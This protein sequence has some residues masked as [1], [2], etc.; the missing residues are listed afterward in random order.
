MRIKT[1]RPQV[2]VVVVNM[3]GR[4][5]LAPCLE[6]LDKVDYSADRMEVILVDNGSLDGSV[7]FVQH[8]HPD[9]KVIQNDH[10]EGFARA[11]NQGA[12]AADGEFVVFLNNDMRVHP[13][14]LSELAAAARSASDVAA[15]GGRILSWDGNA[16][17]FEGAAL[18]FYGMGFQP[19][20]DPPSE[21]QLSEIL[22]G[23]G[24]SLL[25]DR[26]V[27]MEIGGFDPDYFAYFE[28]VDL[29][30]RMWLLGHRVLYA[31][32]ALT[33]HRGHGTSSRMPTAQVAV[34]YE[35][36][37][38]YTIIK[39]YN[40]ANLQRVLPAALLLLVRRAAIFGRL[41]KR[42]FRMVGSVAS[43]PNP[44]GPTDE[45][46]PSPPRTSLRQAVQ[47]FAQF[48]RDSG[49]YAATVE[50]I[51][52]VLVT[53]HQKLGRLL[54]SEASL[55]P[56]QALAHLVAADDVIDALPSLMEKRADIQSRRK[57]SDAEI[58]GLFNAP[59]HPHPPFKEYISVQEMLTRLFEIDKMFQEPSA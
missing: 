12:R 25:V 4:H 49:L 51:R 24:G 3:D 13:A 10:N 34:L 50:A 40:E 17:D 19:H 44:Y 57:R 2:S 59:F 55:V 48:T 53:G 26:Q 8:N 14:W 30:W 47:R 11:N 21:D 43:G 33:Y 1:D 38:L 41:D 37:A 16:V 9:V 45:P 5:H 36:N 29:G 7:P 39:N 54:R 15:V 20:D 56:R 42:G 22:F 23:C 28:D 18:N 31:P 58:L 46:L 32:R 6:S 27:F 35:R 52:L